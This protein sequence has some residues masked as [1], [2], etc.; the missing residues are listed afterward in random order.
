MP[1]SGIYQPRPPNLFGYR[2][3]KGMRKAGRL[4]PKTERLQFWAVAAANFPPLRRHLL[5][6]RGPA[7]LTLGRPPGLADRSLRRE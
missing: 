2:M 3:L 5:L 4:P 1:K 6:G 7:V